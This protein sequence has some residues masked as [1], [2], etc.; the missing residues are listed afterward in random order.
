[1]KLSLQLGIILLNLHPGKQL[2]HWIGVLT[3]HICS[4]PPIDNDLTKFSGHT[5]QVWKSVGNGKTLYEGQE[6]ISENKRYR[7][8]LHY[9]G[10]L[11]FYDGARVKWES[12]TS[13]GEGPFRLDMQ[14]DSNLVLYECR[15]RPLNNCNRNAMWSTNT[16]AIQGR[17]YLFVSDDGHFYIKGGDPEWSSSVLKGKM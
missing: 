17:G 1:M 6:V 4:L 15:G 9:N 10:S 8:K 11:V 2:L 7:L 14:G 13:E 5:G 12:G 16:T 3:L